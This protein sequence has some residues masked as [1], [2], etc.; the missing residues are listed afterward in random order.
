MDASLQNEPSLKV[1]L[2]T[3]RHRVR[4]MTIVKLLLKHYL[5]QRSRVNT[6]LQVIAA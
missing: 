4:G 5:S 6:K 1:L 3:N 2:R